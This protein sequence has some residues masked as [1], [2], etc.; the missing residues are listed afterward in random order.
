M[1]Y[2]SKVM[3][4]GY[5]NQSGFDVSGTSRGLFSDKYRTHK[6]KYSAVRAYSC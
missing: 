6:Y 4:F 3:L 1:E 5:R 2:V